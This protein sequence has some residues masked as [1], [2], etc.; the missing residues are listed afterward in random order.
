MSVYLI[1]QVSLGWSL[2]F[3]GSGSEQNFTADPTLT[4]TL[5]PPLDSGKNVPF[6][7]TP[8]ACSTSRLYV[9]TDL[10]LV[11]CVGSVSRYEPMC[12]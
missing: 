3:D 9:H 2:S 10:F 1:V 4:V 11:A 6:P 12:P 8:G 5:A 7:A